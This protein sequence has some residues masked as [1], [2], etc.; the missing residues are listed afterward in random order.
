M[1]SLRDV[2]RPCELRGRHGGL[3]LHRLDD[4]LIGSRKGIVAQFGSGDPTQRLP[5]T[6]PGLTDKRTHQINIEQYGLVAVIMA[7][8]Q[9]WA[10][11]TDTDAKL[12]AQFPGQTAC[13]PQTKRRGVA[14][15]HKR[16]GRLPQELLSAQKPDQ[17]GFR[18]DLAQQVD[19]VLVVGSVNSSNS[20]RLR[21]LAEK[22]GIPAFLVDGAEDIR[23]DWLDGLRTVGVT[24]GASA[25]ES[26][27]QG[28]IDHLRDRGVGDVSELNGTP[29]NMEFAL[30]R[31]LRL[32]VRS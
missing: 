23:P 6:A 27:V 5:F 9:Q 22:Q 3:P 28:V 7:H 1:S 16:H 18:R 21:E 19:L 14:C 20:N 12:F 24:A 31:E 32:S 2:R 26:L 29:E 11:R 25:P 15:P 10:G 8:F 4:G 30:P 17:R 13:G